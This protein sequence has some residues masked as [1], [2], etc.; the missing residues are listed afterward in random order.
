MTEGSGAVRF[1]G[2]LFHDARL[3]EDVNAGWLSKFLDSI[4]SIGKSGTKYP[5]HFKFVAA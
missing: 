1:R 3:F 4:Q 2:E 5:T